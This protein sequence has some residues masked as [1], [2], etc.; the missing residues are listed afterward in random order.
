MISKCNDP[1]EVQIAFTHSTHIIKH[2]CNIIFN[3]V[4]SPIPFSEW[5]FHFRYSGKI[6]LFSCHLSNVYGIISTHLVLS[7][8]LVNVSVYAQ[9]GMLITLHLF[10]A[11]IYTLYV[12][13]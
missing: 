9:L 1:L 12:S 13:A 3:N 8:S 5:S 6:L 2:P 4:L 11:N 7:A 10:N